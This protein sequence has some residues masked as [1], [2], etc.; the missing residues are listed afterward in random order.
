MSNNKG[1][2]I[3]RRNVPRN[4]RKDLYHDLLSMSWK[5][6][7][8]YFSLFFILINSLFATLYWLEPGSLHNSDNSW[9]TCFFFSVQTLGTIGYGFLAP[10]TFMAN[11]LVTIE[12]VLGLISIAIMTGLFFATF[13]RP[14]AK[15]AFTEN[16]VVTPWEGKQTLI[17]RMINLRENRIIDS[18][19][20]VTFLRKEQTSH[21][22]EFRRF[23]DLKLVRSKIPLL[24]MSINVMHVI[25]EESPLFGM[26]EDACVACEGE[27]IVAL[28]G[29]DSTFGQ[30][31][32]ST[33]MYQ[34]K[35]IRWNKQF[36]DMVTVTPDG[37]R[38]VDFA[39]FNELV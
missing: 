14:F 9:T 5:R 30:T 18:S 21:G 29:T 27:F 4:L 34:A 22:S 20:S 38:D 12:A 16:M 32:H 37:T 10:A 36:K 24:A 35:D 13:S 19:V 26:A 23:H 31:I 2:R 3:V 28:I 8:L 6:T 7:L 1:F 39:N 15:V 25:D 33:T 17:F 11:I